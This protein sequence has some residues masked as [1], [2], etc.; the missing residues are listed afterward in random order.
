MVINSVHR[1]QSIYP[2]SGPKF[3]VYPVAGHNLLEI[4]SISV[5]YLDFERRDAVNLR[6]KWLRPRPLRRENNLPKAAKVMLWRLFAYL[7][8]TLHL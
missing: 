2:A 5:S 8:T 4:T 7:R 6:Y 1:A 3:E